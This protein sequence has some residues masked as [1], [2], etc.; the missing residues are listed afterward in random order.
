MLFFLVTYFIL[1]SVL[2][3]V[4]ALKRDTKI[5]LNKVNMVEKNVLKIKEKTGNFILF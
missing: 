1:I 4:E 5:I 2:S 3:N